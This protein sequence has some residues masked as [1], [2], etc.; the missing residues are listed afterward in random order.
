MYLRRH[1]GLVFVLV[2]VLA[3]ACQS[4]TESDDALAIDDILVASISPDPAIADVATD[5]KTY[6]V[7]R[8]DLPDDILRYD[9]KTEFTVNQQFNSQADDDGA[10]TFPVKISSATIKVQQASGGIVTAPTGGEVEHYESVTTAT[11]NTFG[12]VGSTVS[13][14]FDVWYDLPSLKKEA[15]ITVTLVFTDADGLVVTKSLDVKVAP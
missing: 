9:W 12:A 15:L 3:S 7:A 11:T 14:T 4:P 10:L 5:G 6:R 8:N 13:L 2:T 1:R